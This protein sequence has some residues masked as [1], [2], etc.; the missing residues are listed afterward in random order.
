[1]GIIVQRKAFLKKKELINKVKVK[2]LIEAVSR[3]NMDT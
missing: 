1:M 2:A 3:H